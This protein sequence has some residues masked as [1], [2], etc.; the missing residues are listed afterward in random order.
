MSS[1]DASS[2]EVFASPTKVWVPIGVAASVILA[3]AGGSVWMNGRLLSM[4]FEIRSNG[5]TAAGVDEKFDKLEERF[6]GFE[7]R[8]IS[9]ESSLDRDL[10][11]S[12][13][14]AWIQVMQAKD[15]SVPDL[16]GSRN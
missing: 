12:Q 15:P 7:K 16:P 10:L 9:I 2:A 5:R 4:E 6:H 14:E 13:L 11:R 3:V 8:V 1:A